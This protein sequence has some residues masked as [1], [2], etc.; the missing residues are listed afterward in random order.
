[1]VT[2]MYIH[3]HV[4]MY[5]AVCVRSLLCRSRPGALDYSSV[6]LAA[7]GDYVNVIKLLLKYKADIN[8]RS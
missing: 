4:C 8:S 2:Y 7:S 6:S 5:V 3:V 1:M